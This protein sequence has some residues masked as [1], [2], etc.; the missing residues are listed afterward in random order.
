MKDSG[1]AADAAPI[2]DRAVAAA[3]EAIRLQ[4]DDAAAHNNLGNALCGQGKV[5]EAIAAHREAIRLQPD[6]ADGPLQPRHRP[7]GQGKVPE[8]IAAYREAIRLKPDFA[9]A[10]YNLGIV[11]S[12]RGRCPR[13]S[14]NSARPSGSSPTTP[15]AHYNLGV[16][17][18]G[19]GKVSEA[20]DR[21]PRGDPAQA[22]LR[23]G[24]LQPRHRPARP[25]K[26][27]GC[28]GRIP[29]GG[30]VR[31]ARITRDARTARHHPTGRA[32]DRV[33]G[34][35]AGRPEGD[36]GPRDAAE[37][38]GFAQ[39]CYDGGLYAA[40]ARFWAEA[41]AADPKLGDDRQAGHRYNAACA[42]ALAA[43]G[44]GTDD[45]KPDDAAR[46]GLRGQALGWLKAE[47]AAWAKLLDAGDSQSRPLVQQTLQ[48]WQADSDLAG[49]RD[50]GALA[51][52]PESERV[53]WR[54][55]WAEVDALLALTPGGP[56]PPPGR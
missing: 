8:A 9:Q 25:A 4:P 56:A 5:P 50:T 22:R 44:Q 48:H 14:P 26:A 13:P 46:A 3:R 19:Q 10:H 28:P 52:L 29:P 49:V 18:V 45:P 15:M 30:R 51:K 31:P 43:A 2:L 27:E 33:G 39:L 1:R 20:I 37:R 53:A 6:F 47:R 55:L 21:M 24:P 7:G 17:L 54:S 16:V 42:A 40:A 23:R 11:L 38:L 35:S 34:S 41:L 12:A 32:A 36:D